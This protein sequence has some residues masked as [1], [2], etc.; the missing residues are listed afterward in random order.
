MIVLPMVGRSSRFRKAGYDVPKYQ[1]ELSGRSLFA[2]SAAGFIDVLPQQGLLVVTLAE[3]RVGD[4]VRSEVARLGI[5]NAVIAELP[6]MTSGQADTVR[7]GVDQAGLASDEPLTIF[8]IDTFRPGFSYPTSF[9]VEAVDGYL[10]CFIGSGANWSNVVVENPGSDRVGRTSEKLQESE[11]C[12]TGLYHFKSA[13]LFDRACALSQT[14]SVK[15]FGG[16]GESYVAPIYNALIAEGADI[17]CA[18]IPESDVTF[19]GVP[20]EYE[21]LRRTLPPSVSAL[22]ARMNGTPG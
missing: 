20:D 6:A 19:C 10:E 15:A 16:P 13:A 1:L 21:G 12:C 8:N 22:I 11:Y 2:L 4:F 5:D 18:T 17:R 3:D 7:Q 14:D 9:D